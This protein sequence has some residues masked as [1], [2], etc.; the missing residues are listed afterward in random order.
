MKHNVTNTN[1]KAKATQKLIEAFARCSPDTQIDDKGYV[2]SFED[3]LVSLVS[4][5]DPE[6][7]LR[8]GRGNELKC[9]FRAAYSSSALVVNNFAPFKSRLADLRVPEMSKAISLEFESKCKT[10]LG[11]TPPHLDVLISSNTTK[12]GIESKLTEHLGTHKAEF[13]PAYFNKIRDERREQAYFQEMQRLS[14]APTHYK[15]LDAAQLIKHAF[16]L[17]R[18]YKGKAVSLCYLFW[19]PA[20]P[21]SMP[22]FAE[23]REEVAEFADHVAGATPSFLAMSYPELWSCW[24]AAAPPWLTEHLG[25][26]EARYL[27]TL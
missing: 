4:P 13:S 10:G 2:C 7:D 27:V 25:E 22:A 19:E 15:R 9:N 14:K 11:G 18:K 21:D 5:D 16:G 8:A 17:A 20:N 1:T 26:L 23:H 3:N 6:A 12:I 24:R